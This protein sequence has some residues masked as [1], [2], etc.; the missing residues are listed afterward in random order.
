MKMT[1]EKYDAPTIEGKWQERWAAE[2]STLEDGVREGKPKFY[3]LVMFPYPSGGGLHMGHGRTYSIGDVMARFMRMQGYNVLHPMGWDAF[4]MPAENAAIERGLHPAHWTYD[5]I[6]A[7]ERQQKMLAISYDWDRRFASC[8][9]EYY[10]WTQWLFLKFWERGLAYK[11]KAPV[12]W[13]PHCQTVLAN[14]QVEEG[15]CWRC[16]TPVQKKDLEQWF[17]KITSYADRLLDDLDQLTEWPERVKTMQR[18]WIGRSTGALVH[19]ECQVTSDEPG[20]KIANRTLKIAVFTTR[21]DTLWGATFMVLAPEHPLVKQLVDPEKR[22]EVEVYVEQA[23]RQTDVERESTEKEKTGVWT[24]AYAVNPVN[25]ERIP[26]WIADY[27]LVTY[28][29]GAI[30]AV[31]AHDERDFAFAIQYGLPIV[32]VI[33][34]P[35]GK[36]RS[37][38][39]PEAVTDGFLRELQARGIPYEIRPENGIPEVTIE[40]EGAAQVDEYLKL[41]AQSLVPNGFG[42]IVGQRF[43]FVF[44]GKIVELDSVEADRQIM[45][46]LQNI[47]P[48]ARAYRTTME[49]LHSRDWFRPLCLHAEHGTMVHSGPL[50]GTPGDTAY[51]ETTTWL[52]EWTMGKATINYR[53]RD[54]LISRQRYWGAPIPMLYCQ[55]CGIVPVPEKDLPVLLPDRVTFTG[56]GGSPLVRVKEFVETTCPAC[57]GPARR[58]TDTMDTFV[59]SSWYYL[60]YTSPDALTNPSD[61]PFDSQA[62]NYWLPVDLYIGGIEHAILHLLYSRFFTKVLYDLGLVNFQE[63]FR[64]LFT[65]GMVTLGGSAMSKSKGNVVPPEGIVAQYGADAA[66][67]YALFISP[68]EMDAEWSERGL[69]GIHRFLNKIWRLALEFLAQCKERGSSHAAA[70]RTLRAKLHETIKKVTQD[71]GQRF[72]LNTAISALMELVNAWSDYRATVPPE[73]Q[74]DALQSELLRDLCLLLAPYAPHMS[75]ELWERADLPG[76]VH[77]QRWP[78]WDEAILAAEKA[79]LVIQING[80]LRDRLEVDQGLSEKETADLVLASP[81]VEKY[82]EGRTVRKVIVVPDKIVNIVMK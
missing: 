71:I 11:K 43:A 66:R 33:E 70:E 35:D 40:L 3:N 56:E 4:G 44:P 12:N 22:A 80:K 31:P 9:P 36:A 23:R 72:R 13:C 73:S 60:R 51:Q 14:E 28:G 10:R 68:P 25:G 74:N 65:H 76:S 47:L 8:Q 41:L 57:G 19:F 27:V 38:V 7:I 48:P 30:M 59:D 52:E 26:I 29:T 82:L 46:R 55:R 20:S 78:V 49:I 75:A 64:K 15:G 53:L 81:K 16:Q 37:M 50:S 42:T 17:F 77:Q 21:P 6:S 79:T 61:R 18:N 5:A 67:M 34:R 69:E 2:P 32:P 45:E 24:G 39:G 1:T 54:W 58:E 63:P 62:A